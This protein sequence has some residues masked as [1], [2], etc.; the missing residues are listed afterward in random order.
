MSSPYEQQLPSPNPNPDAPTK[1]SRP[2]YKMK[3]V[4]IPL[5]LVALFILMGALRSGAENPAKVDLS[6]QTK[7]SATT[8]AAPSVAELEAQAAAAEKAAADKVIADK[9]GLFPV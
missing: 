8:I 2:W 4:D 5:G 3:R 7:P 1:A 9:V 6:A